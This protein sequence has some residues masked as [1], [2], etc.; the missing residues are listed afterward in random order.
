MTDL[1]G[2]LDARTRL[3]GVIPGEAVE[4]VSTI[5]HGEDAVQLFFREAD[6]NLGERS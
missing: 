4:V 5:R 1:F 3:S 2:N 6:G